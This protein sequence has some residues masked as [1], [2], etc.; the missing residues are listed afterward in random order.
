MATGT[1]QLI[2]IKPFD[3]LGY[4]NWEFR[5]KLLEEANVLKVILKNPPRGTTE[6]SAFKQQDV[7]SISIIVQWLSDNTL[8]MVKTKTTAKNVMNVLGTTYKKKGIS[9]H[10]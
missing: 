6:R 7:K 9:V 8:E 3:G 1:Q 10:V 5:I 2:N 4:S